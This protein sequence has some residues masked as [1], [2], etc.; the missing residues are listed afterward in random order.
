M[1]YQENT[2]KEPMKGGEGGGV[3][4]EEK[5]N[6]KDKERLEGEEDEGYIVSQGHPIQLQILER[7]VFGFSSDSCIFLLQFSKCSMLHLQGYRKSFF[8]ARAVTENS[9][10]RKVVL[11]KDEWLSQNHKLSKVYSVQLL[12]VG[13]K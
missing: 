6:G 11:L 8:S 13:V 7:A 2:F 5:V 4:R 10:R 3:E 12:T 1:P 9:F